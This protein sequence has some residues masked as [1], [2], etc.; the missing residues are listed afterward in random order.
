[1][2]QVLGV[3]LLRSLPRLHRLTQALGHLALR[4]RAGC[5]GIPDF[6]TNVEWW[7]V[8]FDDFGKEVVVPGSEGCGHTLE[9]EVVAQGRSPKHF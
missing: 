5:F 9:G 7:A 3:C 4:P 6:V 2:R 1:M 8:G